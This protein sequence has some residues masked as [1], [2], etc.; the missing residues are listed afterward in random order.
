MLRSWQAV[1]TNFP[2]VSISM[3]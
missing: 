2:V 3:S 1:A